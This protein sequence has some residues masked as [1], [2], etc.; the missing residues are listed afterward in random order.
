MS[1]DVQPTEIW[2]SLPYYD[3]DLQKYP[4]LRQK[5]EE[6]MARDRKPNATLH[7]RVP[8]PFEPLAGHPLLAA[9]LQR[10][11]SHQPFP[12]LDSLRY[13]L[14]A[15][16][17]SPG[18]D[19]EWQAALDNAQAQLEHQRLRQINLTLLH[20][21]GANAWRVHNYLLE[22]TANQMEKEL[23]AGKQE[24]VEV[25]RERKN[26]QERLG[27]QL[28]MLETRWTELISNVLQ[29]EMANVALEGEVAQLR[30]KE[31][32]LQALTKS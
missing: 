12:P 28:T 15:P 18:T 3:D 20:N 6:E 27:K 23:E 21:Y 17:S 19:E 25:N 29:I 2:D 5:V 1:V 11:Q 7:P 22:A 30:V 13:Q 32:E 24:T 9:E 14:P 8:P 31:E 26:N 16:T 4:E 10:V